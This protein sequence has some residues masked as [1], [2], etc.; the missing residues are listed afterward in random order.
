MRIIDNSSTGHAH[1]QSHGGQT[2][3]Q[4]GHQKGHTHS[5]TEA[6]STSASASLSL[7]QRQPVKIHL[8]AGA[9]SLQA[10]LNGEYT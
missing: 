9:Q 8:F 6:G 5:S 3:T 2:H 10:F 1:G 4:I 7:V